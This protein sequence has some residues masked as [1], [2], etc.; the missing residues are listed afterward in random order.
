M[1]WTNDIA[2]CFGDTDLI[3]AG[4]PRD[5]DRAFALLTQLRSEKVGWQE[6]SGAIRKYL[7]G[8]GAGSAHI[9]QQLKKAEASMKSWLLD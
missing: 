4:H 6:A 2:G 9:D 1:A 3:F 7:E 5:E 8:R